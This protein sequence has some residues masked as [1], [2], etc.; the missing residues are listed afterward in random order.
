MYFVSDTSKRKVD[1]FQA[2]RYMTSNA[3]IQTTIANIAKARPAI[4]LDAPIETICGSHFPVLK[5][6]NVKG[7]FKTVPTERNIATPYNAMSSSILL[8]GFAEY[9]TGSDDLNTVL[10]RAEDA[11]NAEIEKMKAQGK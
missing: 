5:Q 11:A 2:I 1:A 8:K 9:V 6:K 3:E 4:R 10:R 7:I